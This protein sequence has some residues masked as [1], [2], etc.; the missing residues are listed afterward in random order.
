MTYGKLSYFDDDF[1]LQ[2]TLDLN[3]T[4]TIALCNF[5]RVANKDFHLIFLSVSERWYKQI[6]NKRDKLLNDNRG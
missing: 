2:I 5:E 3:L 1:S 4:P 6:R